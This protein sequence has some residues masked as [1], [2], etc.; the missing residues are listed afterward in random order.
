MLFYREDFLED[1]H[2]L[3]TWLRPLS[4]T[5]GRSCTVRVAELTAAPGSPGRPLSPGA[6]LGPYR[7]KWKEWSLFK[8][9]LCK[10]SWGKSK[11]SFVL[12]GV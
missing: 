11:A 9:D 8:P 4:V 12:D 1:C 7:I 5:V 2:S 3:K 6:P 10:N